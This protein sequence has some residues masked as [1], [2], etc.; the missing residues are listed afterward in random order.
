[1]IR[2]V[3]GPDDWQ[4]GDAGY[5]EYRASKQSTT[6]INLNGT[7]EEFGHS[8]GAVLTMN[9]M[10]G[11]G[12]ER[13]SS[14]PGMPSTLGSAGLSPEQLFAEDESLQNEARAIEGQLA[15][16]SHQK[17]MPAEMIDV[18]Q[19]RLFEIHEQLRNTARRVN[20][21]A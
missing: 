4:E 16:L 14:R 1:M 18:L 6:P 20:D 19:A 10:T 5:E 17:D 13:A 2:L 9:D 8:A 3:S 12:S 11:S 21:A 15:T 7:C